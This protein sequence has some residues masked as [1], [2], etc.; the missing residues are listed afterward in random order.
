MD[1]SMEAKIENYYREHPKHIANIIRK[2]YPSLWHHAED[3][4]QEAYL[5]AFARADKLR[6]DSNIG[7]YLFTIAKYTAVDI[8]R[9]RTRE[10]TGKQMLR[11]ELERERYTDKV[12]EKTLYEE[13][14]QKLEEATTKMTESY[15]QVY[16]L[17]IKGMSTREIAEELGIKGNVVRQRRHRMI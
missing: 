3:I 16:D 5:K 1:T 7:G 6:E 9:E 11:E 15:K 10:F 2:K 17:M 4:E 14:Q 12:A 13:Q 8:M